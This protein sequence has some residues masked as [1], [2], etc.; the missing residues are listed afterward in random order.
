MFVNRILRYAKILLFYVFYP[1]VAID[2]FCEI[3][4]AQEL[5]PRKIFV[6]QQRLF[7]WSKKELL[8]RIVLY[9]RNHFFNDVC[10]CMFIHWIFKEI[11]G[12][13]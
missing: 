4:F 9:A 8:K 12:S 3:N 1:L 2:G 10:L 5:I 11:E 7:T 6:L 13:R